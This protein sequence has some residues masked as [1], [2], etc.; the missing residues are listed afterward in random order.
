MQKLTTRILTLT[1]AIV[2]IAAVGC[3]KKTESLLPQSII[4]KPTSNRGRT[5]SEGYFSVKTPNDFYYSVNPLN[6]DGFSFDGSI[7]NQ[8]N[9]SIYVKMNFYYGDYQRNQLLYPSYSKEKIAE[10]YNGDS[11]I[12]VESPTING[13]KTLIVLNNYHKTTPML[14]LYM[15]NT[16]TNGN[17]YIHAYKVN[18]NLG[19]D[20]IGLTTTEQDLIKKIFATFQ[21]IQ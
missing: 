7:I 15:F 19:G 5:P 20:Y 9:D 6:N 18:T 8:Q 4:L 13:R 14:D 1:I 2:S 17:C 3:S 11:V 12:S 21:F 16:N 10:Y